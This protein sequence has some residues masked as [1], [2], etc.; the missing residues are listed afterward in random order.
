M[1]L[2][3]KAKI[4]KLM[5]KI[6]SGVLSGRPQNLGLSG[7]LGKMGEVL[8]RLASKMQ[9]NAASNQIYGMSNPESF[10]RAMFLAQI[11]MKM[12][13]AAGANLI[14]KFVRD[15]YQYVQAPAIKAIGSVGG[16]FGDILEDYFNT[17]EDIKRSYGDIGSSIGMGVGMLASKFFRV[18]KFASLAL[19]GTGV[20]LPIAVAGFVLST[21]VEFLIGSALS[22]FGRKAGEKFAEKFGKV[23]EYSAISLG[24]SMI[25]RVPEVIDHFKEVGASVVDQPFYKGNFQSYFDTM[26]SIQES[27]SA[28]LENL[29]MTA[30]DTGSLYSS[31][32]KS[33]NIS[34]SLRG[35]YTK[36]VGRIKQTTGVDITN[37]LSGISTGVAL[38]SSGNSKDIDS[39][40][41]AFS[42]F[43]A[44]VFR[45]G[46]T[47]TNVA[48]S[49]TSDLADMANVYA[50]KNIQSKD[51][52]KL[53]SGV[54]KFT[55]SNMNAEDRTTTD[56]TGDVIALM[57]EIMSSSAV[58]GSTDSSPLA[59]RIAN[60]ADI[61]GL[62]AKRGMD[63]DKFTRMSQALSG[64]YNFGKGS[65]VDTKTGVL[66]LDKQGEGAYMRLLIDLTTP[67]RSGGLGLG[68][69]AAETLAKYIVAFTK[70]PKLDFS[71]VKNDP[72]FKGILGNLSE[73]ITQDDLNRNIVST[74]KISDNYL[75]LASKFSG[76]FSSIG[77]AVLNHQG[78]VAKEI[79]QGTLDLLVSYYKVVEKSKTGKIS[80]DSGMD[81]GTGFAPTTGLVSSGVYISRKD[82]KI[83]DKGFKEKISYAATAAGIDV[84]TLYAYL[85]AE[86]DFGRNTR[87]YR[88][89]SYFGVGQIGD[90]AEL[91]VNRTMGLNLNKHNERDNILIAA[92][93][94]KILRDR[95][96]K[97]KASSAARGVHL[98]FNPDDPRVIYAAY[99]WGIGNLQ[100]YILKSG[101][102]NPAYAPVEET[103]IGIKNL[104]LGLAGYDYEMGNYQARS[105]TSVETTGGVTYTTSTAPKTQ[106]SVKSGGVWHFSAEEKFSGK[107]SSTT[108]F[109]AM[110]GASTSKGNKTVDYMENL[111][112]SS[113]NSADAFYRACAGIAN[114]AIS[115]AS[116]TAY[117]A[118]T[119]ESD[120]Y[121][122]RTGGR[123]GAVMTF[124]QAQ[125]EGF[126]PGDLLYVL[127]GNHV[128]I[129]DYNGTVLQAGTAYDAERKSN[130]I[131]TDINEFTYKG[132]G[133]IY[134][135]RPSR[136]ANN[137]GVV[138]RAEIEA[139]YK[140]AEASRVKVK[141]SFKNKKVSSTNFMAL[142]SYDKGQ[143][144]FVIKSK[145]GLGIS[146]ARASRIKAQ[147]ARIEK[148]L[149]LKASDLTLVT[150][151]VNGGKVLHIQINTD[152]EDV[153]AVASKV[154]RI[155][156]GIK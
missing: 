49:L 64:I 11:G 84:R 103:R 78:H 52:A 134:V 106:G 29:G 71:A 94:I 90:E 53:F 121:A 93:Y 138:T 14:N 115:H 26:S 19:A 6:R 125:R 124:A 62:D 146:S 73:V 154:L 51:V 8:E 42:E 22:W 110:S 144:D 145:N 119:A 86:S 108:T 1:R 23:D 38:S 74:T 48:L 140:A 25:K 60:Y 148:A 126:Q 136:D 70:N 151:N 43:F 41:E 39:T 111:Y 100:N 67:K 45:G 63:P 132:W 18:A 135:V 142:A 40:A 15:H 92:Y 56:T 149:G 107:K 98:N 118:G 10:D 87:N 89:M 113:V 114:D 116:I 57:S 133:N 20:G 122:W 37:D 5:G 109:L 129:V 127:G 13:N 81:E 102:F 61:K 31:L 120:L 69:E 65:S 117:R 143:S 128:G 33:V 83:A 4:R 12:G 55:Q 21:A 152:L 35:S 79:A 82:A 99:N 47:T 54:Q 50:K 88:G 131:R 85:G 123:A 68:A 44:A 32:S 27:G 97:F 150:Q 46:K 139:E 91:D 17:R 7:N 58:G 137:D 130:L 105:E 77:E 2:E 30:T 72:K 95:L 9:A 112:K 101:G 16:K 153:G 141:A 76:D 96:R 59:S 3:N 34:P 66:T 80:S 147:E 28:S 75:S 104:E 156:E 24:N 155:I 36:T